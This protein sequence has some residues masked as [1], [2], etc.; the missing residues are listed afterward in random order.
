[1]TAPNGRL[2]IV[3]GGGGGI[4]RIAVDVLLAQGCH[5][6]VCGRSQQRLEEVV[7]L[8]PDRI[9]AFAFD[10]AD[11]AGWV[12]LRDRLS[13]RQLGLPAVIITA[14]GVNHRSPFA[15]STVAA[16]EEMWRTNVV[17]SML[18]ARTFV[19][20]MVDSGYGRIVHLSSVGAHVGLGERCGYAAT[21]G[22]VEAFARSLAAEVGGTGVTVNCIAPGAMPTE[23]NR[24]WLEGRDDI[25]EP[26]L[27]RLPEGRFGDPAELRA[28]FE[29]VLAS[30]YSQGSTVIVDGGWTAT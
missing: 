11:E 1:M 22:A 24:A 20:D 2:A 25:R 17:G 26:L 9:D 4:G 13:A 19:S 27:G 6:A 3:T 29:F 18:A 23:L 28:A 10:V 14:A 5:V 30:P 8:A 21:K 15:T 16:W 7:A 12:N